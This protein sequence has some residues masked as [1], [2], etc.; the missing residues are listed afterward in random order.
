MSIRDQFV[1]ELAQTVNRLFDDG[2]TD[3]RAKEIADAHFDPRSVPGDIIDAVRKRLPKVRDKIESDYLH[4]RAHLVS[5]TYFGRFRDEL[6]Q[7]EEE[8]RLCLPLGRGKAAE[9][10]RLPTVGNDPI[11]QATVTRNIGSG[12][13]KAGKNLKRLAGALRNKEI[14]PAKAMRVLDELSRR[15]GPAREEVERLL[16]DALA[17][18]LPAGSA[19]EEEGED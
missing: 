8:A 5:A 11:W 19:D 18:V 1:E 3:P 10:I 2:K 16:D 4:E 13:G 7:S 17:H 6:P 9:G 15:A 14:S 12:A